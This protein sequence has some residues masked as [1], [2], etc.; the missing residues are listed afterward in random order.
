MAE[1]HD[2]TAAYAL[3]ALDPSE[4]REYESHLATCERCRDELASLREATASLA[5]AVPAP[6]P[7]RALRERIL[8]QARSERANVIQ[9]RPRRRLAYALG[10]VAAAAACL[11]IGL[12]V[13]A[14]SLNDRLN[15]QQSVVAIMAA[16]SRV[17][18]QGT[19]GRLF[20]THDGDAVVVVSRLD[21]APKGKTYELWVIQGGDA[22]PAGLFE[23][24]GR[25]VVRL[26]RPV[27][28]GAT[29]AGTVEDDGGVDAP[30][31]KPFFSAQ[32]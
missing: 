14:A 29:V 3:D 21:R 9:L 11:A 7:P 18:L 28:K 4:E 13:W 30:T 2:L 19:D 24:G 8:A 20:V 5:Y 6:A 1:L 32:A 26:T 12:G 31:T 23:G 10:A 27:P 16:G 17:P 25:E 15:R 22:K